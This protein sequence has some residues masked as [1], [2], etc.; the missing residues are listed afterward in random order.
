MKRPL[1]FDEASKANIANLTSSRS[2]TPGEYYIELCPVCAQFAL[3]MVKTDR[4][5]GVVIFEADGPCGVCMDFG[6]RN[7]DV[8]NFV[9]NAIKGQKF[10]ERHRPPEEK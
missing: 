10:L 4:P 6:R 1:I 9:V 2:S 3:N 5:V 8:F 7:P